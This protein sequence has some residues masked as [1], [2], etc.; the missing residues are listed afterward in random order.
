VTAGRST[1]QQ[2]ASPGRA[3]EPRKPAVDVQGLHKRFGELHVLRGISLTVDPGEVLVII[4]SSGSGKSTLL[5]CINRLEE[6]TRGRIFVAGSEI[7]GRGVDID[8]VRRRVGMVFQ[9]FNLFPHLTVLGNVTLALE[10]VLACTRDE[11]RERAMAELERVGLGA[12]ATAYPSK[13]SG[14]QQQR[15]AIARAL[16]MRPSVMLFDEVT[17]ALDPELVQ[18]VLG[19]I[20]R[21][22]EDGMTMLV[23]THEMR[24]AREVAHR[25]VFLDGGRIVESGPPE[26]LFTNPTDPRTQAFLSRVL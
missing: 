2:E 4:G 25:V 18:E 9:H 6:P 23:V 12:K 3:A 13:L 11:A 22:A 21:L 15:V 10:K 5:R 17:S 26:D 1:P 14:G 20:R 19:V 24:F 16:A 7:T 8:L